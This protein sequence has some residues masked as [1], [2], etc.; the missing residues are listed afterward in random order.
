[1]AAAHS[2]WPD[3]EPESKTLEHAHLA[4]ENFPLPLTIRPARPLSDEELM[5]FCAKYDAFAVE[6][7]ADGSIRI[8]PPAFS[9]TSWRNQ[10]LVTRLAM[11]AEQSGKGTVF[12]PDLGVRFADGV[13]RSPD[14]AWVST[15]KW[16]AERLRQ[17]ERP[18]FLPFC[19]EFIAELR[20]SSDR[21]SEVEAKMELWME[22]G[23][24][25]AWLVDPQ[26]KLAVIYRPGQ[27][28]QPLIEPE[29]LK[30]D[31]PIEGF[32]L[33]MRDFWQ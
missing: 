28:P 12:G 5:A 24:Q 22:R 27:E 30:G 18:A 29:V 14:A 21:L 4:F 13:L 2:I 19:P 10:L 7:D 33:S 26:R 25:L 16:E 20:S 32:L 15:E 6:S 3:A 23:A 9:E 31:G 17:G 8:M 11:W 1:M